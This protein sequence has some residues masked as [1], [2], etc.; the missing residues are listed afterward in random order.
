MPQKLQP[1]TC[2]SCGSANQAG[3]PAHHSQTVPVL[4]LYVTKNHDQDRHD[5]PRSSVHQVIGQMGA[6]AD[7]GINWAERELF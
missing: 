7:D 4:H 2:A 6:R 3:S 1:E 5:T